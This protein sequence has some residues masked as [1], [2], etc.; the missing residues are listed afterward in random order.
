MAIIK[1]PKTFAKLARLWPGSL[2]LVMEAR[3]VISK[4]ITSGGNTVA[5]RIPNHKAALALLKQSGPL[6]APSANK[7]GHISPVCAADVRSEF[8]LIEILDGGRC[9]AG[10]E[11]TVLRIIEEDSVLVLRRGVVTEAELSSVLNGGK[12]EFLSVSQSGCESSDNTI[13]PDFIDD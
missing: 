7:F 10:I 5:I 3:D 4:I 6:A 12:I 8:S 11:S 2:T 9:D 13:K 1:F